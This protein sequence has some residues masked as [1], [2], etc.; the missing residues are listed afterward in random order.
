MITWIECRPCGIEAAFLPKQEFHCPTCNRELPMRNEAHSNQAARSTAV[1]PGHAHEPVVNGPGVTKEL[2]PLGYKIPNSIE[3]ILSGGASALGLSAVTDYLTCPERSRLRAAGVRRKPKD[4]GLDGVIDISEDA[5]AFGSVM[6]AIRATRIAYSIIEAVDLIK[7]LRIDEASKKKA[8]H[9]IRVYDNIYPKAADPFDYLGVEVEVR[10]DIGDGKGG[11]LIRSVRYDSVVRM[12]ADG[13]IFSFECKTSSRSG[14]NAL[15][16]YTA[17]KFTHPSLW[18]SNSHIRGKYGTM[19]GTIYDLMV[20]TEVPSADRVGPHYVS[21][22]HQQLAID[23][24]RLPGQ[25]QLPLSSDGAH[26]RMLHSC[27]GRYRPCEYVN[28]CHER[29]YGDYEQA[30]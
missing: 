12:K 19:R 15:S 29:S 16:A 21:S 25:V 24:L 30:K 10:S 20:K 23:Y 5:L 9:M 26:T 6:H 27:Y 4:L 14:N 1:L 11:A 22:V 3:E 8:F 7:N 18:N 28:L 2:P 13:A 17:Q